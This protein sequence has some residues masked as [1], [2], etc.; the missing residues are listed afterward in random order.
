MQEI[1]SQR[2]RDSKKFN[3]GRTQL[4]ADGVTEDIVYASILQN[5]L[6]DEEPD[7]TYVDVDVLSE[8]YEVGVS[9]D[10]IKRTRA[11]EIRYSDTGS[12]SKQLA[13]IKTKR[14][15]GI[16]LKLMGYNTFGPMWPT[17]REA[18]YTTDSGID[19]SQVAN[20]KGFN[21]TLEIA[22]PQTAENVYRFSVK[23]YGCDYT[24][25]E[26][27]GKIKCKSPDDKDNVWIK[28]LPAI[29]S[30]GSQGNVTLRL[31]GITAEG[32]QIIE[33]VIE[34]IWLGSAIGLVRVDPSVTIEDGVGG[35]VISDSIFRS[36]VPDYNYGARANLIN[37]TVYSM[38]ISAN[39]SG[40]SGTA[41][42]GKFG[43]DIY[44]TSFP[45]DIAWHRILIAW[46][47]GNKDTNTATT[48]EVTYNSAKHN[49]V[50]WNT[51]GCLGDGTDRQAT[52]EGSA[53]VTAIN[54]DYAIDITVST[55]QAWLDNAGDNNGIIF[56]QVA[57]NMLTMRSCEA[58]E[59]NKPYFYMEYTEGGSSGF[60]FFFDIGHY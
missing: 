34:P 5:G 31:G 22:N 15:K 43:L 52:P 33:K 11:G 41:I 35:G 46:N 1:I 39:L 32:Y 28:A 60:P 47:E 2:R 26:I 17:L 29:D 30:M 9:T 59:G 57:A 14:G 45:V 6:H 58:T 44:G 7:G 36:V 48:G 18:R 38:L 51:A 8:P 16:S 3:T 21:L 42:S 25:E 24:Y 37:S 53:T 40:Y 55:L 12:P 56:P 27:D 19:I 23:E 49:E 10:R 50:L 13:K 54:S 4:N 20:Y